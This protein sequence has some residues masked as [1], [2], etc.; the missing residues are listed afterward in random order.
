MTRP[1]CSEAEFLHLVAQH[2]KAGT[3]RILGIN[4]RGVYQRI[5]GYQERTGRPVESPAYRGSRQLADQPRDFNIKHPGRIGAEIQNGIVLVGSDAHY[6]PGQKST[7]HRG[8][9]KFIRDMQ[10]RL[11]VLNG[12]AMECGTISRHA[13]IGWENKPTLQKEVECAQDRLGEVESACGRGARKVWTL[14]NH[15]GRFETRLATVAPEFAKIA[16]LH[17]HDHFPAWESAWSLWLND[18]TV[19]KHRFKGGI[20]ATHNN[21]L[22][23]GKHMVTGHL[24]SAK[25]APLTDY[26]GT[27]YGVDTGCLADPDFPQFTDYTEDGPKNWRSAFA[28]LTY[29]KGRLLYPELALVFDEDHIEFRGQLHDVSEAKPAKIPDAKAARAKAKKLRGR[30][31][32]R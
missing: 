15:D 7:A 26:N 10:P 5:A 25:V 11:V 32:R 2:G 6:W 19:I 8:F 24:H 27:R 4:I 13:S 1:A 17:L 30:T 31:R 12:D 23:S 16:G 9:V 14:G 29:H 22:W 20:H 28:V 21:A 3:A 18:N